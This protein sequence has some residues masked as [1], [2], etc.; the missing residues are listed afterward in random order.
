MNDSA[1]WAALV[2]WLNMRTGLT[3]IQTE[4]SG[5]RPALPYLALSLTGTAEI[6]EHPQDVQYVNE[7]TAPNEVVRA[8]PVIDV[9]W[10][11]SLHAF[12]PFPTDLLR[13][14]RSAMHLAQINEPLMPNFV[15]HDV[16]QIR[17][18][19]EFIN[20]E[21]EP[22][23]QMDVIVRGLTRDGFL[24]DVIEQYSFDIEKIS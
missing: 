8:S 2:R 19:P 5:P 20:N 12:G 18:L 15:I 6:R 10:R 21:W 22:R 9:E 16:S 7:G 11:F 3:V 4:Q 14:L 23:A 13:P 24:I 1:L 17:N